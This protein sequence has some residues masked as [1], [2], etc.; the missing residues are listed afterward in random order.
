MFITCIVM[1]AK[2][3]AGTQKDVSKSY[4]SPMYF[5]VNSLENTADPT[6]AVSDKAFPTYG[7]FINMSS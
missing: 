1:K 5:L 7:Q 4:A 6:L 3:P 2:V